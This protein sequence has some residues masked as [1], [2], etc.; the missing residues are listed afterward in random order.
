MPLQWRTK[1][2]FAIKLDNVSVCSQHVKRSLEPPLLHSAKVRLSER[3]V[4]L[5]QHASETEYNQVAT[6]QPVLHLRNGRRKNRE[7]AQDVRARNDVLISVHHGAH[8][9][10]DMSSL[11]PLGR[12][13]TYCI[14]REVW[15]TLLTTDASVILPFPQQK[16]HAFLSQHGSPK[17]RQTTPRR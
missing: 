6:N 9:S 1:T 4:Q 3:R 14:C 10:S 8:S 12:K 5:R 16:P 11:C 7:Q 15:C 13:A 17:N 2:T